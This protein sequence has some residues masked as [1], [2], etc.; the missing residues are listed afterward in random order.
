MWFKFNLIVLI[1]VAFVT[2]CG[3]AD[4]P[5][6]INPAGVAAATA[7]AGQPP[8]PPSPSPTAAAV[9]PA[10]PEEA[11]VPAGPGAPALSFSL[12]GGIVGFCD[13]LS[14][15]TSGDFTLR[16]CKQADAISGKLAQADLDS[17]N[18]WLPNLAAFT[19]N[20]ED[21][22][23]QADSL[24]SSLVFNGQ[25]STPADQ[26][27]QQAIFQWANSLLIRV[28]PQPVTPPTPEP[29]AVGPEGLCPDIAR[30]AVVVVDFSRPAGLLLVDP[31][32]QQSCPI[33]LKQPPYGRIVAGGG[34]LFYA[35]FDEAAKMVAIWELNARGE[36]N[37]LS[38]TQVQMEELGP[39][40]FVVS[41]DGSKIAW[42]R[43]TPDT[44][45]TPPKLLNDLWIAN[46]DGSNQVTVLNQA[47]Q[48]G[49]FIEPV[50]FSADNNTLY[51]AW[52]PA[53]L[54]GVW[55]S[56]SGRYDSVYSVPVSGGE[57][58]L[59]FAC[60]QNEISLCIGD[61]SPQGVLVQIQPDKKVVVQGS[62]GQT[63]AALTPPVSDY[64]GSP[65]F[66]PNGNLAFVAATLTQDDAQN[67]PQA[68]PGIITAL[69][70]PYTGE[71]KTLVSDKNVVNAWDWLDENRLIFGVLD[72]QGNTGTEMA[73]LDGQR[74]KL[75]PN[76]ALAVL[77]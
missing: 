44:G 25:G 75:S 37:P 13:E 5:G 43:G 23:G 63:L 59:L 38:F 67:W 56:L 17:L 15:T 64:V 9:P 31:T 49:R 51:F 69:L 54:G 65:V 6:D 7:T 39:Y 4:R 62:D 3:G 74:V 22:A 60:P 32:T 58:R 41:N 18:S 29:L 35:I 27:Q 2:A 57:P 20:S 55:S 1:C 77:R 24:K 46:R 50:R 73:T 66:G 61:I 72:E 36:Q 52:Q 19:L 47:E 30:P 76:F 53:G 12:S 40:E 21:N 14:L 45:A 71:L 16:T 33:Q 48:A 28:R 34:S 68:N 70:P 8:A 26:N 42:G 11:T 10:A